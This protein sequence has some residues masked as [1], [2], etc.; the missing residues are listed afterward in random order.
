MHI[1]YHYIISLQLYF[2]IDNRFTEHYSQLGW[3][4]IIFRGEQF[5][6]IPRPLSFLVS[7]ST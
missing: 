3:F 1:G 5:D 2:V 4:C 7:D 6:N